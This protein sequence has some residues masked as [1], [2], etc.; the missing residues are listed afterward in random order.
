MK[1]LR[2]FASSIL[3][4]L[5]AII[6]LGW[7]TQSFEALY[8]A[9]VLVMLEVS[10]SFDN[11]VVNSKLL[12]KLSIKW[13]KRFLFWG[14]LIA[15]FGMRLIFPMLL[16]Y[17]VT[18]MSLFQ[19][20]QAVIE[21]P[22]RY[23]QG[24]LLGMPLI[25]A[26]GGAFLWLVFLHFILDKDRGL[27]WC[28]AIECN[29][30]IRILQKIPGVA[31]ILSLIMGGVLAILLKRIDVAVAFLLGI[32]LQS[33]MQALND[34]CQNKIQHTGKAFQRGLIGF[35]YLEVLDASF[36]FDGVA[37]SF[38]ITSNILIILVG[39]GIGALF[40]RSFTIYLVEHKTLQLLPFLDH[41]AHYAIGFLAL[42]MCLH[43]FIPTPE[44]LTGTV[45][46]VLLV[47]SIF[48]SLRH[49]MAH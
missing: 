4:S 49:K 13:R 37:G 14:I 39:L 35:L 8:L 23:Q 5:I 11:A 34:Y 40:V 19:V 2:L 36:S 29:P 42:V 21:N 18:P 25:N 15:V 30:L 12:E 20:I 26:F 10:L 38:A 16:V 3:L 41:G 24:L 32:V 27:V 6:A 33:S 1:V 43:L 7:F 22:D 31:I 47:W 48:S 46:I 45:S 17:C 28:R 44:W 9:L